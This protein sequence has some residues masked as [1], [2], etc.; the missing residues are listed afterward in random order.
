V[1]QHGHPVDQP[2]QVVVVVLDGVR[3]Q[4][5]GGVAVLADLRERKPPPSFRLGLLT[6]LDIRLVIVLVVVLVIVF[7]M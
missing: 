1:H 5:Q 4:A 6:R 7:V 2:A 3:D